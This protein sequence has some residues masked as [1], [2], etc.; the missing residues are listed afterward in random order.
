MQNWLPT[1]IGTAAGLG[2]T[3]A[4]A[5]QVLKIWREGDTHAISKRMWLIR[6]TGFVLWM[7][8][9]F[10][11]GQTL[12]VIFNVISLLLGGTILVLKLREGRDAGGS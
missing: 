6:V 3:F 11:I 1:V 9:G 8:Y 10:L 4:M 7:S 12:I 2:S 5:P